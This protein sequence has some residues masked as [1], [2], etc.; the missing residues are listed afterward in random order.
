MRHFLTI[1]LFATVEIDPLTENLPQGSAGNIDI[2]TQTLKIN[3]GGKITSSTRGIGNAGSI[4]IKAEDSIEISGV[5]P[6]P[7]D[8]NSLLGAEVQS[9]ATGNGGSINVETNKLSIQ[10]QGQ[11]LVSSQGSGNAGNLTIKA[12]NIELENQGQIVAATGFGEGGN[13]T[14]DIDENLTLGNNSLIS[15]QAFNEATGGNINIDTD[16]IVAFPNQIDGNGNDIVANAVE[17]NGGEININAESLLGIQK[18]QAVDNRTNDIDASSEFSLDGTVTINTPDINPLQGTTELPTNVVEPQQTT[19]QACQA[20]R[21]AA[22][23]NNLVIKGKGGI[24]PAPNLPLNSQN[25]T[26][27]GNLAHSDT[28]KSNQMATSTIKPIQLGDK[29]IMPARGV[30]KTADGRIILTAYATDDETSRLHQGSVNCNSVQ[31]QAR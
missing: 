8:G 4:R 14:L 29:E 3:D 19:T 16:F 2:E 30:V 1:G 25:I 6:E 28:E 21:E 23:K 5:D 9:G 22:A 10:D 12:N 15:A 31:S 7:E 11:T 26:I 24:P 18:R 20:Y 13:I 17:E 27:E